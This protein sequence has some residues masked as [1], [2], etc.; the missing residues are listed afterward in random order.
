ML[1]KSVSDEIKK[2]AFGKFEG[3]TLLQ[4]YQDRYKIEEVLAKTSSVYEEYQKK[5]DIL[6]EEVNRKIDSINTIEDFDGRLPIFSEIGEISKEIM[7]MDSE[8]EEVKVLVEETTKAFNNQ[9]Q[10]KEKENPGQRIS[11][12]EIFSSSLEEEGTID[13]FIKVSNASEKSYQKI[14]EIFQSK[15]DYGETIDPFVDIK[16]KRKKKKF[17]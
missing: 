6:T 17:F 7:S 5:R 2:I 3:K 4:L 11:P 13:P 9:I 16:T 8:F 12:G 14:D 10:V 1:F 15:K